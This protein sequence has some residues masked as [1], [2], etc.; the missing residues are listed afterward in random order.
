MIFEEFIYLKRFIDD[1]SINYLEIIDE[2]YKTNK[3]IEI[4]TDK[5]VELYSNNLKNKIFYSLNLKEKFGNYKKKITESLSY[6]YSLCKFDNHI[7]YNY[8]YNIT[9]DKT[10]AQKLKTLNYQI[11]NYIPSIELNDLTAFLE[12]TYITKKLIKNEHYVIMSLLITFILTRRNNY[13]ETYLQT[14]LRGILDIIQDK[15]IFFRKYI[16]YV[17]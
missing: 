4:K 9:N 1:K 7:L 5:L 2:F 15:G 8:I 13:S 6:Q 17:I 16:F 12:T 11:V 10:L 3:K 14:E